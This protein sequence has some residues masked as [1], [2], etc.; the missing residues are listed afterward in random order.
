MSGNEQ[1]EMLAAVFYKR[2]G[3]LAPGKDAG[4]VYQDTRVPDGR[5]RSDLWV[6]WVDENNE[7]N[8]AWLKCVEERDAGATP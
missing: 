1:F 3:V 5:S 7:I 4:P 8:R 2:T 6:K